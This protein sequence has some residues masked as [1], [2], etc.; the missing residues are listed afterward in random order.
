MRVLSHVLLSSELEDLKV[1]SQAII[2]VIYSE[3]KGNDIRSSNKTSCEKLN[4]L[5]KKR[6]RSWVLKIVEDVIINFENV[7]DK[8]TRSNLGDVLCEENATE[9]NFVC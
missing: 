8:Y 1:I 2:D 5:L 6:I 4:V 9:I 7:N 3:T